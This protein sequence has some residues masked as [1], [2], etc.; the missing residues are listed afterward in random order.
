LPP[1]I[2]FAVEIF[3]NIK[4]AVLESVFFAPL[5]NFCAVDRRPLLG[6]SAGRLPL[7]A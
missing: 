7:E 6:L 5:R 1:D 3:G 4:L 2:G